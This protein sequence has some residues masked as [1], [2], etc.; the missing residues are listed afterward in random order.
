MQNY[1]IALLT[2]FIVGIFILIG[3]GIAL[4]IDKKEKIIDFSIGLAFGVIIGL[5][6]TDL[7]PEIFETFGFRRFYLFLIFTVIGYLILRTLDHFIPD[8]H[9]H[10]MN[11]KEANENMIH[12]GIITTLTLILHNIIEGM[13]IYSS[14]ISSP[15]LGV[16][17]AL[18]IGFH[19]IPLGM[20]IASSF[21][22]SSK[23]KT[24]AFISIALVSLST[25]LGGAIMYLFNLT[26][27]NELFLG[28]L[29]STTLGMLIFIVLDELLPRI[30]HTKETKI[31][32]IGIAVGII[33][34]CISWMIG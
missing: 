7:L 32:R 16:T 5:I 24:K 17:L 1:Q 21:Y 34:L 13:A 25:L 30:K 20:I 29:L 33:F 19:N 9:E 28:I 31:V 6:I 18:G 15:N 22:N 3:A 10:H 11:K 26:E 23:T 8:H 12:I 2:T 14:A 4:L 27:I